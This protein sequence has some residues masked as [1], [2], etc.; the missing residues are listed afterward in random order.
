MYSH[1]LKFK[2]EQTSNEKKNQHSM[3]F[4]TNFLI[5]FI[6]IFSIFNNFKILIIYIFLQSMSFLS[7]DI[8]KKP[9]LNSDAPQHQQNIQLSSCVQPSAELHKTL[10]RKQVIQQQRQQH[11]KKLMQMMQSS[12]Q[13]DFQHK[14]QKQ[15]Q[16]HKLLLQQQ[17]KID[18]LHA[19]LLQQHPVHMDKEMQKKVHQQMQQ[20]LMQKHK[21]MEEKFHQQV[22]QQI[23]QQKEKQTTPLPLKLNMSEKSGQIVS[24][25]VK[26]C[27]HPSM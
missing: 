16:E 3:V 1:S 12:Q 19:H 21:Q 9:L 15:L 26:G 5:Y 7:K 25:N 20:R 11:Q 2:S 13:K 24:S 23:H 10:I 6:S 17:R 14:I 27:S 4:F 18:E 8:F 22:Q